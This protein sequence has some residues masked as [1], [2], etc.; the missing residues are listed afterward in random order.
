MG[1]ERIST[2]DD[3]RLSLYRSISDPELAR[4]HGLFVAEGRFVVRRV[5]EDARYRVRSVLVNDAAYR[6]L[7]PALERL[8]VS[9]PI[10]LCETADFRAIT[11]FNLHRGCVA[12]VERPAP[13]SVGELIATTD[14]LVVL[15]GVSNADNIGGV[16]RNAAAFGAGGVV[17]S[18]ACA[19]PWYRKAIRTSMAAVLR[20]P[21]AYADAWPGDLARLRQSG[22][23][24]V[25]LTARPPAEPLNAFAVRARGSRVAIVAGA[26]GSGLAPEVESAADVRV[27]I[28]IAEDVDSLNVAVAVAI[29]LYALRS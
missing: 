6:D 13:I 18:P 7:S 19:D 3:P 20:V 2:V 12:L 10:F 8:V 28:P 16:F 27:R 17:L 5:L 22:F 24:L 9:P 26:E 29:A 25:A 21:F 11:G 4:S 23:T 1:L 15:D 14:V